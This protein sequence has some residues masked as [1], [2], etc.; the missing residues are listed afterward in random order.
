M[1]SIFKPFIKP[2]TI[3]DAAIFQVKLSL[4]SYPSL[5]TLNFSKH[6]K[7]TDQEYL[8]SLLLEYKFGVGSLFPKGDD[9]MSYNHCCFILFSFV[10]LGSTICIAQSVDTAISAHVEYVADQVDIGADGLQIS[11]VQ[12][13][14]QKSTSSDITWSKQIQELVDDI[15]QTVLI[16]DLTTLTNFR[17]RWSYTPECQQ[18]ADWLENEFRS[19]GYTVTRHEYDR[20][21]APNIV[22]E[23]KGV[24]YPDEIV[25]IISHFDSIS[26]E[27][28]EL[29]PGANDNGSGTV[30]LLNAARAMANQFF[31]RTI[32]F[33]AFSGGSQGMQGSRAY[34]YRSA[35]RKENIVGVINLDMIGSSDEQ[36]GNLTIIG[37]TASENLVDLFAESNCLYTSLHTRKLLDN[38]IATFDHYPFGT[39]GYPALTGTEDYPIRYPYY[40]SIQDTIDK[41][42]PEFLLETTKASTAIVAVLA[43][44]IADIISLFNWQLDDSDGDGDGI[45]DPDETVKLSV[46]LINNSDEPSGPIQLN[47][48]CFSGNQHVIVLKNYI[49]L[50]GIDPGKRADNRH[51]P[52][53][54]LVRPGVPEF[55]QLMFLVGVKCD[56][57]HSSGCFF[58]ETITSYCYQEAVISFDMD[59]N[60]R[61]TAD[62]SVWSWGIPKGCGGANHGFPDPSAGFT[63]KSVLGTSLDGD[64][65]PN[66]A[67]TITSPMMDFTEIRFSELH[68]QRWLNIEN[69]AFDQAQIWIMNG[70]GQFLIWENPAEITDSD[71]QSMMFDIARYADGRDDV[72]IAFT[73]RTDEKWQYSGWNLDD[74]RIAGFAPDFSPPGPEIPADTIGVSLNMPITDLECGDIF[75]LSYLYWNTTSRPKNNLP[76]FILLESAGGIWFWP[77]WSDELAFEPLF[78]PAKNISDW[79]V[80]AEFEWPQIEGSVIKQRFWAA[81]TTQDFSEILGLYDMVEWGWH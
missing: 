47:L 21:M 71:W 30:A 53:I 78:L 14:R 73:I 16:E 18:A 42:S 34:A 49:L 43:E 10:L 11:H 55:T 75:S 3:L 63:G 26:L 37:N 46:E 20:T 25:L 41:I 52:F 76:L 17:T 68:F 39:Y 74:V 24:H 57:P 32:R 56:A 8:V 22:A 4:F 27:P 31:E 35:L 2:D 54:V 19:S 59:E 72:R 7:Y 69:P 12:G 60:P 48:M 6:V 9:K 61:W 1:S 28:E 5:K 62:G 45:M 33:V 44:P 51:D 15:S 77:N 80:I 66:I 36:P 50:P 23:K 58:Y 38:S 40:H 70:D 65:P 13:D 29:A 64:Y 81:F 67:A 79:N